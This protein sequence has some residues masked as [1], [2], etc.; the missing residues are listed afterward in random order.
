MQESANLSNEKIQPQS[1]CHWA[2]ARSEGMSPL[3]GWSF[4]D[5]RPPQIGS[6]TPPVAWAFLPA[7][8][9]NQS[10]IATAD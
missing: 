9:A 6:N 10:S 1:E 4:G 3:R 2:H 7:S 8:P 5:E